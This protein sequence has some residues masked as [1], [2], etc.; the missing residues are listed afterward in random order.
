MGKTYITFVILEMIQI[1]NIGYTYFFDVWNFVDLT[2]LGLN[3]FYVA[4][5]ITNGVDHATL[6][7]I[8]S[9]CIFL[10]W[11]KLFYWMR[12]FKPFSAFIRMITEILKDIQVFLVMLIISL[13]AFANV[14]YV[15][16]LNRVGDL[17]DVPIY[18]D[19][20]GFAPADAMIHAYLTGLGE[21]GMDNYSEGDATATWIMFFAATVIVQL[22]FMNLLIAIMGESFARVTAI[23][24][25]STYKELCSIMEDHI[26]LQKIDEIFASKRHI[27]WL[28]PDTS[29]SGGSPMER[30]LTQLKEQSATRSDVLESKILR[31]IG[32]LDESVTSIKAEIE[33]LNEKATAQDDDSD[34][35]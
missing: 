22:V 3:A 1:K 11:F 15:L 34:E 30:Q 13:A 9:F 35:F 5:E 32:E 26:W 31:A 16:N 29:T 7:V 2:S 24:Q 20:V 25:Q 6:Q 10:M 33:S 19:L 21:F 14:I 17:A 27:L 28:T 18:S 4:S 12:L 23:M 8:A